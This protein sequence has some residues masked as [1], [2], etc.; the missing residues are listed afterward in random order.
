MQFH[1]LACSNRPIY[2]DIFIFLKLEL[3]TRSLA[4]NQKNRTL[5][6][7]STTPQKEALLSVKQG[8]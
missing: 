5:L 1:F 8:A 2:P 4:K 6:R 7:V 3:N